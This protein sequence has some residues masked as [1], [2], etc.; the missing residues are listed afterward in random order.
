MAFFGNA[1]YAG[2][3]FPGAVEVR[4]IRVASYGF[5]HGEFFQILFANSTYGWLPTGPE[6]FNTNLSQ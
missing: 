2:I 5:P 6:Y 4:S 1:R 3:N